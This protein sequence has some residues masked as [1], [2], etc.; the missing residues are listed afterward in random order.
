MVI[1][2]DIAVPIFHKCWHVRKIGGDARHGFIR[3][4]GDIP[5]VVFNEITKKIEVVV[6]TRGRAY[7]ARK[8]LMYRKKIK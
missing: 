5:V 2:R 1:W 6:N 8:R 3:D 7:G 4:C